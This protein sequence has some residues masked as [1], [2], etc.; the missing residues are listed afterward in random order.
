MPTMVAER[1]EPGR[2]RWVYGPPQNTVWWADGVRIYDFDPKARSGHQAPLARDADA[3]PSY[4]FLIDRGNLVR[5]FTPSLTGDQPAGQWR[6]TLTPKR[7]D[8][9]VRTLVLVVDRVTLALRGMERVDA[10]GGTD[11][12]AFPNLKENVGLTDKD[13][14]Y[15]VPA[16]TTWAK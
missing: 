9:D 10:Q 4:L 5:D 14:D 7:P 12:F 3:S 2:M 15:K 8:P 6:L 13:L 1:I 16:G 11:T